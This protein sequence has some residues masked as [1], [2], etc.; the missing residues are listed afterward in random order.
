MRDVAYGPD[1]AH[2]LDVYLPREPRGAPVIF[3]VHG[4]AWMRGDKATTEVTAN[5]V[6]HWVPK[7]YIVVST[8][9]RLSPP[10]PLEQA[11]DVSRALAFA[12][13][14]ARE[15][16]ADP[17]RFALVGHSSGAHLVSLLA[18]DPSISAKH[19]ADPWLGTVALDSAAFDV[20]RIMKGRHFRFYDQVFRDDPVYWRRAS[21]LHRLDGVPKP[22]F[23]VC[24]S[25]RRR[26][27][28]QAQRY[29]AKVNQLGGR[30]EMLPIALSHRDLNEQLGTAGR[31]TAAV[32]SFLQSLGLP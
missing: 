15:W 16:G 32:D 27:C 2:R 21:P 7:G 30:A 23:A 22:F 26:S 5:K 10:D 3:F 28:A 12:Q 9:Y 24:S 19:E 13:T 17:A 14:Q 1:P 31:Y 20:E 6:A 25:D 29:V 11:D 18:S 8:N 4:G